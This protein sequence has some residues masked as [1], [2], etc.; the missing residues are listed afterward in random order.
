MMKLT[1]PEKKV[2]IEYYTKNGSG[3]VEEKTE[4][5]SFYGFLKSCLGM[6]EKFRKGPEMGRKYDKVMIVVEVAE[7]AKT[8]E[9]MFEDERLELLKGA[10]DDSS[11][12]TNDINRAYLPYYD[13]VDAVVDTDKKKNKDK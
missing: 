5:V 11:W 8:A 2:E 4:E 3:I 9:I 6:Y 10:V 12:Q 7:E 13:A 1:V